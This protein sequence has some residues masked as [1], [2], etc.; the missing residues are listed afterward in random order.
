MAQNRSEFG[1]AVLRVVLRQRIGEGYKTITSSPMFLLTSLSQ[2]LMWQGLHKIQ[3][4]T[5]VIMY[6]HWLPQVLTR[7][8]LLSLPPINN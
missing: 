6:T 4:Y 5:L 3:A 8:V 2:I 1:I 7:E